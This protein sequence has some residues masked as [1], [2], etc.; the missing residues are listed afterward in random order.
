MKFEPS[1]KHLELISY[2]VHKDQFKSLLVPSRLSG[3]FSK[4]KHEEKTSQKRGHKPSVHS[5]RQSQSTDQ[6]FSSELGSEFDFERRFSNV[7]S[8]SDSMSTEGEESEAHSPLLTDKQSLTQSDDL[9]AAL[10]RSNALQGDYVE[11]K[12][13]KRC[14]SM[15]FKDLSSAIK[16]SQDEFNADVSPAQLLMKMFQDEARYRIDHFLHGDDLQL[17]EN[18]AAMLYTE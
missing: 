9:K 4:A 15:I 2:K 18:K 8:D 6:T 7:H 1:C 10:L 16:A 12:N 13:C 5:D 11:L 17:P 3:V 14:G